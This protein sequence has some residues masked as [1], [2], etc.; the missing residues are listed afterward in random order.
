MVKKLRLSLLVEDSL[1]K[2]RQDLIA[3]HG[4]SILVEGDADDGKFSILMDTG[5]SANTVL[6]NTN[7][8][9]ADL[10]KIS[11][12]F[13]S[14]GH[15]D[16]TGGLIGVLKRIN[17]RILVI[18]HPNIFEVKLKLDPS[19]RYI[20]PPFKKSDVESAGGIML[21]ARNPV[22]IVKGVVTSGEIERSTPFEKVEDFWKISLEKF[23]EDVLLDDQ[24]LVVNFKQKGLVIISG[25]AHSGIINTVKQAQRLT[26]V[27]EI[28]AVLGGFHLKNADEKRIRLTINRLIEIDPEIIAP[29]HCTGSKAI[30][31]IAKAFGD[32]CKLL[33]TGDVIDF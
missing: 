21:L 12:I 19:I 20:G 28:Y 23:K 14:H 29:C 3:K 17:K 9:G 2:S 5:P 31:Q 26:G 30:G 8:M 7:L 25:C 24:A 15:Y 10:D 1:S 6:H 32:R 33:G 27:K 22:T 18:A 4:L 16:H 13:L 11:A